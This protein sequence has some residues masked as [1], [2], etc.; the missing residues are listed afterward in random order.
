MLMTFGAYI[1]KNQTFSTGKKYRNIT[2]RLGLMCSNRDIG[3]RVE[4]MRNPRASETHTL[5]R[6]LRIS[7]SLPFAADSLNTFLYFFSSR[8]IA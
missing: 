1:S 6:T 7:F 2:E 3:I 4:Y 8:S 5:S